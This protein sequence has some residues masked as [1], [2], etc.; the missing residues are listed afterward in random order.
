MRTGRQSRKVRRRV[1]ALKERDGQDVDKRILMLSIESARK[2]PRVAFYSPFSAAL[3]NYLKSVKPRFS[4]SEHVASL[5]ESELMRRYPAL[6]SR[7]RR[8][9]SKRGAGG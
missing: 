8:I 3:L 5:V 6:G 2:Q 7:L 1:K 9:M 4:I